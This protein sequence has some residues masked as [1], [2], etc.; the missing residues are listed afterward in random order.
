[1][2]LRITI[3]VDGDLKLSAELDASATAKRIAAAL[4]MRLRLSRWG[5][6]YYGSC[7]V[8]A[9]LEAGARTRMAVGEIAYW[10]PGDALCLFFGPT[11]ASSGPEP[12][13]ASDV[14]PVGT[15]QSDCGALKKLGKSIRVA[16][17]AAGPA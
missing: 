3:T 8:H 10:P 17:E 6:E 13:A 9:E 11:P 7:G 5:D 15:I 2:G 14:N 16:I 4:P 12:E 1:M